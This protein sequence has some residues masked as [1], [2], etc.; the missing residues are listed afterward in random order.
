MKKQKEEKEKEVF[1]IIEMEPGSMLRL[2][3]HSEDEEM[4]EWE[5]EP[6]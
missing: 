4:S 6:H 3:I 1:K 2:N 5:D